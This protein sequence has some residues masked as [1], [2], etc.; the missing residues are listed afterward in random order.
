MKSTHIITVWIWSFLLILS[1]CQAQDVIFIPAGDVDGIRVGSFYLST[2]IITNQDYFT[3]IQLD[4]YKKVS[5]WDQD[6]LKNLNRFKNQQGDYAPRTW[7]DSS[8]PVNQEFQPVLGISVAEAQAYA[9][10]IGWLIPT[11]RMW[12]L[13]QKV[14]TD[15]GPYPWKEEEVDNIEGIRMM[16]YAAPAQVWE[17]RLKEI[18]GTLDSLEKTKAKLSQV[19][20]NASSIREQEKKLKILEQKLKEWEQ[21]PE[22]LDQKIAAGIEKSK[23]QLQEHIQEIEKKNSSFLKSKEESLGNALQEIQSK[24]QKLSAVEAQFKETLALEQQK[25]QKALEEKMALLEKGISERFSQLYDKK[26]QSLEE[27]EKAMDKKLL[28]LEGISQNLQTLSQ[29]VTKIKEDTKAMKEELLAVQKLSGESEKQQ[30]ELQEKQVVPMNTRLKSLESQLPVVEAKIQECVG[31]LQKLNVLC[32]ATSD[33][34][35]YAQMIQGLRDKQNAQGQEISNLKEKNATLD[36]SLSVVKDKSF[37][38]ETKL[39][40]TSSV[41]EELKANITSLKQTDSNLNGE[42]QNLKQQDALLSKEDSILKDQIQNAF[43]K[44]DKQEKDITQILQQTTQLET[45][46]KEL[47]SKVQELKKTDIEQSKKNTNFDLAHENAKEKFLYQ[48]KNIQKIEEEVKNL[49][50]ADIEYSKKMLAVNASLESTRQKNDEI[51]ESIKSLDQKHQEGLLKLKNETDNASRQ[52]AKTIE[53]DVKALKLADI[54]HG[55]KSL[56]LQGNLDSIKQK[57]EEVQENFIAFEKK[58]KDALS[59]LKTEAEAARKTLYKSILEDVEKLAEKVNQGQA[60]L[61]SIKQETSNRSLNLDNSVNSLKARIQALETSQLDTIRQMS[62]S[63]SEMRRGMMEVGEKIHKLFQNELLFGPLPTKDGEAVKPKEKEKEEKKAPEIPIEKIVEEI[64]SKILQETLEK[65]VKQSQEKAQ[66][67]LK[68]VDERSEK[69]LHQALG[70]FCFELGQKYYEYS[71]PEMTY[72]Y[73]QMAKNFI[74]DHEKAQAFL[75]ENWASLHCPKE[76]VYVPGDKVNLGSDKD[77]EFPIYKADIQDFYLDKHEVTRKEFAAFIQRGGY[78]QDTFWS[79]EGKE[80]RDWRTQP[81]G[82]HAPSPE[83]ENLPVTNIN[84]YE[85]EAYSKWAGK[86]LPTA[87]EWEYAARG[88]EGKIFPWGDEPAQ[89]GK[90]FFTNFRQ[91]NEPKDG[92]EDIAPVDAFMKD[93]SPFGAIGMAGNVSEWCQGVYNVSGSNRKFNIVKGGSF[94]HLWFRLQLFTTLGKQGSESFDYVGFRCVKDIPA[95]R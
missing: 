6:S 95:N 92:Y 34:I 10:N 80:W 85:A 52:L 14:K 24:F 83:E 86:R 17:A 50:L 32:P 40:E 53:E 1:L 47:D 62:L 67:I 19:N 93:R 23:T 75:K 72:M 18:E 87:Q 31:N 73:L 76:M 26:M 20:M 8:P 21:I 49:K 45:K 41:S 27:K 38:L 79:K 64:K 4:G 48:E 11:S 9:K 7:K 61:V 35:S 46:S 54:E 88:K 5:L 59:V 58:M 42:L 43:K 44:T 69:I 15:I 13:A 39:N 65:I 94:Q 36:K 60:A 37:Q 28:A 22:G 57:N 16:R 81:S 51:V 30:K 89:T 77:P 90:L 70:E 84:Y 66:E 55:K 74:P 12:K 71:H 63:A 82:W 68:Q 56:T 33:N 78:K 25:S 3:F 91:I 29:D 2:D